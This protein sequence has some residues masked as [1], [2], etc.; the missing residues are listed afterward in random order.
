MKLQFAIPIKR[1][2]VCISETHTMSLIRDKYE[3][4]SF[5]RSATNSDHSMS[6]G[7]DGYFE[8]REMVRH[9]SV[10]E[11]WVHRNDL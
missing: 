6:G 10:E 1:V 8:I 4:V 5:M 2:M 3:F 11:H 7:Q 9:G